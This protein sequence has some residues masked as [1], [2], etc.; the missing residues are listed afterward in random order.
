MKGRRCEC[1][2]EMPWHLVEYMDS[3]HCSC[4]RRYVAKDGDFILDGVE[5]NPIAKFDREHG[6]APT[7]HGFGARVRSHRKAHGLTLEVVAKPAGISKTYLSDIERGKRRAP[8]RE[9]RNRIGAVLGWD[10]EEPDW[11]RSDPAG[12]SDGCLLSIGCASFI[13]ALDALQHMYDAHACP[14]EVDSGAREANQKAELVLQDHG[15]LL[16]EGSEMFAEE[17]RE[18]DWYEWCV[19]EAQKHDSNTVQHQVWWALRMEDV[20]KWEIGSEQL[21]EW[22]EYLAYKIEDQVL[23]PPIV[24]EDID[25]QDLEELLRPLTPEEYDAAPVP[26]REQIRAAVKR[27]QE[28]L[29]AAM[30]GAPVKE[31]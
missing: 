19:R 5:V 23:P 8:R 15:R 13:H 10:A 12:R 16:R 4:D 17:E 11:K 1:G 14:D 22:A 21:T 28:D 27:G 25:R 24:T 20:R 31:E 6:Y 18:A 30:T 29:R 26:S 2:A 9:L 7:E 3:H